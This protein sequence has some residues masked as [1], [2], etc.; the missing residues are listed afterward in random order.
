MTTERESG[1]PSVAAEANSKGEMVVKIKAYAAPQR[2]TADGAPIAL[3]PNE[4]AD[5]MNRLAELVARTTT[6]LKIGLIDNGHVVAGG[7][8]RDNPFAELLGHIAA[9]QGAIENLFATMTVMDTTFTP[10][11]TESWKVLEAIKELQDRHA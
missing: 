10:A 6:T 3:M 1:T 2:L 4:Q 11:D 9:A 7:D 5:E 8:P